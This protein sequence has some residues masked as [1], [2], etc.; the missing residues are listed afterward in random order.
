MNIAVV[1][2]VGGDIGVV[3]VV[4]GGIAVAVITKIVQSKKSGNIEK[5]KWH[6]LEHFSPNVVLMGL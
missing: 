1:V 2:V 3:V 5:I 4:V 6:S